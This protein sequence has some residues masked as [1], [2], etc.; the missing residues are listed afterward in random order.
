MTT[1]LLAAPVAPAA[2]PHPDRGRP[3][4][5]A[6]WAR[7]ALVALLGATAVLYLWGLGASGWANGYY[8][9]AVQAGAHSWKAFFFGSLDWSN[10]ITVD[11]SPAFL[12]PMELSARVVGVN[13]WSI[14]VPQ[15]LEGVA[16]VALVY[17]TVRRWFT[18]AAGLLAGAVVATTPVAGLIFRYNNPDAMLVLLLAA[19]TYAMTRALEHGSGRWLAAAFAL[20]GFGFLAKMLQTFL[21]VP[22][23]VLAYA[24]AAPGSLT[25]R[26]RQLAVAGAAMLAAGG[27]WVAAVELTPGA[28][29]P[30]IGGSQ[31]NSLWNLIFG[32]N[33]FGRLTGNEAGSVGGGGAG[34]SRWGPTGLTRLL[35][36]SFGG[37]IAWLLPAALIL[38]AAGI[39]LTWRRPRTDRSRAALVLSGGTLLVTAA[40]F[41]LGHGII[42]PYYTV[43]LA[44]SI[45]AVIGVGAAIVWRQRRVAAWYVLGVAFVVTV[46]WSSQL[47]DR[48]PGWQPWLRPVLLGGGLAVALVWLAWPLVARRPSRALVGAAVVLALLGPGAYTVATAATPH[49]GAIPSAGPTAGRGAG[50]PAPGGGP[51]RPG[52]GPGGGGPGGGLLDGARV[53]ST[54]ARLLARGGNGFRWAAATVDANNAASYQLAADQPVMAIGGF[55]GTD[56]APTLAQFARDVAGREIHYF[57]AS[58]GGFGGPGAATGATAAQIEAWVA[59]HFASRTVDGVTVYDLTAR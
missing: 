16:T 55:N 17:A 32:Y 42:H 51:G 49:A 45:A 43:A 6:R 28:A 12:W 20:V 52:A 36:T 27:W 26:A 35:N 47:L 40:V 33:G 39:V 13:A 10:F 34:G 1:E 3:R 31:N 15:A 24:L 21:V 50:G 5:D 37:Q 38:L 19:A 48:T 2:P 18:P 8:S 9:A 56:P 46:V 4:R 54:L 29:R 30:Y 25:R 53:S 41:S 44:P 14:L 58:G 7:P 59:A 23:F 11:K 22:P 57:V